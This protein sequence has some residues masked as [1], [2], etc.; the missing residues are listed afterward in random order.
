[1][2][3]RAFIGIGSN[4][5]DPVA[6]VKAAFGELE[7]LPDTCLAARSSLYGSRPMGPP[8]QPDYVNAVAGVD[9]RLPA[10]DL[11]HELAQIEDRHGRTRGARQWGPRTLDLDLLLYGEACIATSE[12]TVP[13]PGMHERDFVLVPL[14]EIAGDIDVPGHGSL[15]HLAGGCE[16]HGLVRLEAP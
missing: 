16:R 13:H 10:V 8:N 14:A 2:T 9:T 1:M 7:R 4:L 12:L 15:S 5:G 11:L 6:R 3:V